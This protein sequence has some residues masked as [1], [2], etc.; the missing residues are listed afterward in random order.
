MIVAPAKTPR[1]I[2]DKLHRELMSVVALP[3]FKN[4]I[5]NGGMLPMDNPSVEGLQDF[6]QA[7]IVRWG[8]VV[9]R[10]G[11]AGTE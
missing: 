1:L 11:L 6:V 10:A 9:R 3:E 2:V 7:E 5:I 4:Q 8:T